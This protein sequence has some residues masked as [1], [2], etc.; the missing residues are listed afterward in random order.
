MKT[1][2][3]ILMLL[4]IVSGLLFGA[5][6]NAAAEASNTRYASVR[7]R[8]ITDPQFFEMEDIQSNIPGQLT[9]LLLGQEVYR[10]AV[11]AV[12]GDSA[13][14][15]FETDSFSQKFETSPHFIGGLQT[16]TLF[17]E[18]ALPQ[19]VKPA[20]KE[21]L[22]VYSGKLRTELKKHYEFGRDL[23]ERKLIQYDRFTHDAEN[24][25][26]ELQHQ[27]DELGGGM[28]VEMHA[29][30]ERIQAYQQAIREKQMQ[31]A[32]LT[33]Q[34][35]EIARQIDLIRHEAEIKKQ[36]D[37]INRSLS[38]IIKKLE[39]EY[40]RVKLR[41]DAGAAAPEEL[42]SAKEQILQAKIQIM[43]RKEE[44]ERN[45]QQNIYEMNNRL[46]EITLQL[47]QIRI[48]EA[49]LHGTSPG[50][51]SESRDFEILQ[52]RIEAAKENLH[53]VLMEKSEYVRQFNLIQPPRV[54]VEWITTAEKVPDSKK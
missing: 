51:L 17:M 33:R 42:D 40:Q 19:D 30:R 41:L 4:T 13:R 48:E 47:E 28:P 35:E 11:N 2:T 14:D 36:D 39:E 16:T 27:Q 25:L 38:E 32:V 7:I 50:S 34:S 44:I 20:A 8:I 24:R 46:R 29:V 37:E 54:D 52:V 9:N 10:S 18:I 45:L 53:N 22:E 1:Q 12:L 26:R 43:R 3:F 49:V 15:L 21:F 23:F 6:N 5:D 31:E